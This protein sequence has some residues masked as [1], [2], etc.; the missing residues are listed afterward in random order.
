MDDYIVTTE[1][2]VDYLTRY[3]GIEPGDLDPKFSRHNVTRLKNVYLK[4][5]YLI[6]IGCKFVGHGLS[7]DFRIMS[8]Q[9]QLFAT[10]K[11]FPPM[12]DMKFLL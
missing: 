4:I 8:I 3:S 11:S 9:Q 2:V 12:I 6:D 10:K 1:P 5:R 7:K